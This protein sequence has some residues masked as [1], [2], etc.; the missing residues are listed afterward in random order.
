MASRYKLWYETVVK[1]EMISKM[2]YKNV[3][4]VPKLRKVT[5]SAATNVLSSG[6]NHPVAGAFALELISGQRAELTRIRVSNSR[7]KVRAGFLEGAKVSLQGE[8]M[9]DFVDRL[10]TQV[11]PRITEFDG[12][13]PR[14]F[15]GRGNFSLGIRDWGYFPEIE[16]QHALLAP[17]Q[18]NSARGIGITVDTTATTD[19]E[20]KLFLSALRFPFASSTTRE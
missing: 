4:Q 18:L 11:L 2:Q 8:P 7:Y 19:T 3:H 14:S 1:P 6:L 5:L 9:Y 17:F 16:A 15:D 12:L 20:A 13:N 10:V